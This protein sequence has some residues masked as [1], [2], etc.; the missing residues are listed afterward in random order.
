MKKKNVTISDIAER[1]CISKTTVSFAFN[2]PNRISKETAD[3]VYA[4]AKE[5]GYMPT[6]PART[7]SVGYYK[8]IGFLLPQ[9]VD[10][11]LSNPYMLDVIRGA[12]CVC[13]EY[14]FTLNLI[15]P[16]LSSVTAA[17]RNASVDGLI[18]LGLA[19]TSQ[20]IELFGKKD[21]PVVAV[22]GL[23]DGDV[24]S[25]GIDE[26]DAAYVQMSQVLANGHR[27]ISI[28][29][30]PDT[31]CPSLD[32]YGSSAL[33]ER[34]LK[35]YEKALNEHDMELS[36]TNVISVP[37]AYDA[38]Y[39]YA[40]RMLSHH[41]QIPSCFVCMSDIAA[42][43]TYRACTDMK[44]KVPRDISVVGFDGLEMGNQIKNGLTTISQRGDDKGRIAARLIFKMLKGDSIIDRTNNIPFS[45]VKGGTLAPVGGGAERR[46][47][48]LK[49]SIKAN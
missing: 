31:M 44:F 24:V 3:R 36:D 42:I 47:I 25:V 33:S 12:T 22:D 34:R 26:E 6:S 20:A 7:V 32:C 19:M 4:A 35:G 17:V 39:R 1:L 2:C 16:F 27:R 21:V 38:N 48:G 43:A 8:T 46:G 29:T 10:D 13:E 11:C 23:G 41:D 14:G 30:L 9:S 37:V 5:M 49:K 40:S 15:P 45:F 18:T 28:L